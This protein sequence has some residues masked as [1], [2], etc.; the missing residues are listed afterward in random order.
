VEKSLGKQVINTKVMVQDQERL[1]QV[2]VSVRCA[3]RDVI[4]G[5]K[6]I[7][8][9]SEA[10]ITTLAV[11]VGRRLRTLDLFILNMNQFKEITWTMTLL[12]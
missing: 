6:T 5:K 4:N 8:Q 9:D 11:N 2:V 7:F 10:V 12:L 1:V 3:M